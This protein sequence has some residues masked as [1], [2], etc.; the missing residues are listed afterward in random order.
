MGNGLLAGKRGLVFGVANER[1]IAWVCAKAC[2]A[3]GASLI[4]SYLGASQER[5]VRKLVDAELPGSGMFH[6]D[7]SR[8]EEIAAFF[9]N[10]RAEWE[11]IDFVIHSVAF[12]NREDLK[13]TFVETSRAGFA[14]ALDISAYSLVPVTREAAK[15]M[16]DGGSVVAMSY[17]GAEKVIP[18]YNVMGVAKAALEAACRYLAYDMGPRN[19]RVNCISPGPLRTLSSSAIQG[20]RTMLEIA[21]QSAPLRRTMT[22][23]EVAKTALYLL[24]DLSSGVTGEVIHVDC[25]LNILGI[26]GAAPAG[27]PGATDA[28]PGAQ[29]SN[30]QRD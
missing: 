14:L 11:S 15:I 6:C 27:N 28:S 18:R 13:D 20:M 10:V 24:S 25:G 4:F 29:Q 7:V 2:A 9:D 22:Q 23:E 16:R 21:Q 19:I 1:S 5:R 8:D 3:E 26:M 12:A 30:Q 17:Y